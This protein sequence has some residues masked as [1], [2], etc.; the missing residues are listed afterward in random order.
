MNSATNDEC[1]FVDLMKN[2]NSEPMRRVTEHCVT[3]CT[4]VVTLNESAEHA[5]NDEKELIL[6]S[7]SAEILQQLLNT[8]NTLNKIA[9]SRGY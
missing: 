9:T 4:R 1:V 8:I 2:S 6:R 3:L 5:D 7:I